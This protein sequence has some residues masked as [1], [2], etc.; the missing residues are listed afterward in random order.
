MGDSNKPC[1]VCKG[2]DVLIETYTIAKFK[3]CRIVCV[4]SCRKGNWCKSAA[5]AF[6]AWDDRKW[7]K[8]DEPGLHT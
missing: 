2:K 1:P 4:N 8:T 5:R 7:S 3:Y 6:K